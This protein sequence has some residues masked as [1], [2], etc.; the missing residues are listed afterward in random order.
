MFVNRLRFRDVKPL[1]RDIPEGGRELPEPARKRLLLQGGNGSGKTTILETIATLWSYW[2]EW[3]EIGNEKAPPRQHLKHP[4]L[5]KGFAAMEIVAMIPRARPIWIGMGRDREWSE[6]QDAYP[7]DAFAGLLKHYG[8][9]LR[10]A[11]EWRIQLPPSGSLDLLAFRHG[12]LVARELRANIVYFPS[13]DR[14]IQKARN[15]AQLL[16][17][18][19]FN[20]L[21]RFDRKLNLDSVLLTVKAREPERFDECLK[22]VNLALGT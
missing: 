16:D 4:L 21:A 14:T 22:F 20:W 18:I 8:I 10:A 17:T 13:E 12:S 1:D 9:S 6:L 2:G 15:S 5:E 3:I 11:N 7:K 19:S